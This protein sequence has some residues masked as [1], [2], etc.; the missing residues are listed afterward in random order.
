MSDLFDH[1]WLVER[2]QLAADEAAL[3]PFTI[4]WLEKIG[5][6]EG[7]RCL[8]VGAGGGSIAEW[9]C[10]R[11]GATGRVVAT[12]RQTKFLEAIQAP[13]LEVVQYDIVADALERDGFDFVFARRVLEHLS[14]P[15]S[16]L[17]KMHTALCPG[18]LLLVES[19]DYASFCRVSGPRSDL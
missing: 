15:S 16:A 7:W 14:D 2:K 10:R 3:D 17:R 5:V 19:T 18:G 4:W 9:L 6:K 8:E 11:V 12:D 13:N 1:E